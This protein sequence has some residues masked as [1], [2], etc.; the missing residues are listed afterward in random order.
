MHF[1]SLASQCQN[2]G[3]WCYQC[4]W[5]RC[6]D[7]EIAVRNNWDISGLCSNCNIAAIGI[8]I[9][10]Q[11]GNIILMVCNRLAKMVVKLA[12]FWYKF[13]QKIPGF[14]IMLIQTV[15]TAVWVDIIIILWSHNGI[16]AGN[17]NIIGKIIWGWTIGWRQLCGLTPCGA[18]AFKNVSSANVWTELWRS[19]A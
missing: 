1:G 5:S 11:N 18:S 16:I 13:E 14:A 3:W 4:I 2:I 15:R 7:N 17:R 8:I 6:I 19:L 9:I 10:R 12:M